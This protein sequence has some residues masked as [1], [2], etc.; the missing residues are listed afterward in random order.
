MTLKSIQDKS[1]GAMIAGPGTP[2]GESNGDGNPG[3]YHLVWARDLF[4][5]AS[6][7]IAAGDTAS[8]NRAV[9]FLFTVQCRQR[10]AILLP[11]PAAS[12]NSYID[13]Q[14]YWNGTQMDETACRLFWHGSS[15]A[16]TCGRR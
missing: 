11:R 1:N 5:F 4:K 14:P 6:A 8:A 13:G 3:G 9:E 15:I 12:P 7:L 2:W 16:A 10:R